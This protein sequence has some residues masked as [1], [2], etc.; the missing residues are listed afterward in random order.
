[1]ARVVLTSF[2]SYGDVNPFI[3]L[4]L[5][6]R[7]R[8]HD[9]V[10][11]LPA[12]YR[13]AVAREELAFR[14][15]R[16]DVDIHDREFAARIMDPARG[17]DVTCGEL[18]IPNLAETV[19]DL[20]AVVAGADLLVTHP[21]S[22]AGPIVAEARGLPWASTVLSPM[23]FFSR[24]DPTV[25]APSPWMH[26]VTSRSRLAARLFRWLTERVTQK[27]AEPVRRFRESQG[28]PP[29]GNPILDGQHSPYLVL[30]LFS[31]VLG[32]PQPDW[33]D[34]VVVT[35]AS[36]YNGPGRPE[37][38]QPL[39]DFLDTGPPP[40]TF[41]L[42]TSAVG[43]A[44]PFYDVST[45]VARS[46][47]R[48]AVLLAGDTRRTARPCPTPTS[49]WQTSP[50]TTPSSRAPPPSSTRV[51]QAR[52]TRR[53]GPVPPCSWCPTLTTSRTTPTGSGDWAWRAR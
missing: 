47:G 15:V 38:P 18:I 46:P 24:Y 39:D 9:P 17:T 31:R 44:G 19:A 12:G 51:G 25:P 52:S 50:A 8:G 28:L 26:A 6:L 37:L 43:A 34:R 2:G 48:R 5:A 7:S 16:P 23:S 36:F 11:A 32:D 35:G 27:W 21:A 42:G 49:S 40:F 3:G 20:E 13:D 33:P 10:L 53:C 1:M 14:P 4:A 29:G 30:E 45:K 22:L 41:T